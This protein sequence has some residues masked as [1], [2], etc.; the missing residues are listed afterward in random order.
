MKF[1]GNSADFVGTSAGFVSISRGNCWGYVEN[2]QN[3]M[4]DSWE[5]HL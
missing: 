2:C 3:L 5:N 4:V 1:K